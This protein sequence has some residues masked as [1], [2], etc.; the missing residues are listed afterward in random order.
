MNVAEMLKNVIGECHPATDISSF[1]RRQLNRG[2]QILASKN[3]FTW[4]KQYRYTLATVASTETYT[5]SPLVDTSRIIN[6]YEPNANQSYAAIT[7]QEFRVHEPNPQSGAS[8]M[9]RL[10]GFS[11]VQYQP[12]AADE[13][14]LVSNSASDTAVVVHIQGLNGSGVFVTENVTMN[15]LTP[16]ST[17]AQFT[18]IMGLSKSASSVGTITVSSTIGI[19]T[20]TLVAISPVDRS[21]THP[22][23]A[24]FNVPDS[25]RTCYYDFYMKLPNIYADN[26]CSLIPEPFHDAIELYAKFRVFKHLNNTNMATLTF[27]ELKDRYAEI[28]ATERQPNGVWAMN[29]YRVDGVQLAQL[30]SMY[31]RDDS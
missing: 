10:V 15:G 6:F 3:D 14:D 26:D 13:I 7:D 1:I 24:L 31:P 8:Y 18:K 27:Q 9:Y 29:Q 25:V 16:V 2:Q 12:T 21:T 4:L 17:T 30:P 23:I 28:I 11:P 5:L 20:T 19:T 22:L